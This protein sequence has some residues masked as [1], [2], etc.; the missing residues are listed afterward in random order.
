M[1]KGR[2]FTKRISLGLETKAGDLYV[3]NY[4]QNRAEDIKPMVM[5]KET[6]SGLELSEDRKSIGTW[7]TN[8]N[9]FASTKGFVN[10]ETETLDGNDALK[11]SATT[12][13][14]QSSNASVIKSIP[15]TA[16]ANAA[17]NTNYV[18]KFR[19]GGES[20]G[21]KESFSGAT[22]TTATTGERFIVR[23]DKKG[24]LRMLGTSLTNNNDAENVTTS[25]AF[26]SLTAN[27]LYD[28]EAV[29]NPST[30]VLKA[31]VTNADGEQVSRSTT[32]EGI[33]T[34]FAFRHQIKESDTTVAYFDDAEIGIIAPGGPVLDIATVASGDKDA[35]LLGETVEFTYDR[36]IDQS[37]LSEAVVT[38]KAGENEAKT[39]A[40][41]EYAIT[42]I[43]NKVKVTLL[44][45]INTGTEYTVA[46]TG[47]K[48]LAGGQTT[49]ADE[50]TYKT[51]AIDI[52]VA[53]FMFDEDSLKAKVNSYYA[54][55]K[56]VKLIAAVYNSAETQ[57]KD[58]KIAEFNADSKA[59]T[60]YVSIAL[61]ELAVE[62]GD[63][64]K[65]FLWSDFTT[66]IPYI[67]DISK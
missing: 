1:L 24:N 38:L 34:A 35:A 31:V 21:E 49:A 50:F 17:D 47:V 15:T 23:R 42:S 57:L 28:V 19:F 3:D 7:S 11:I 44:T 5:D 60:D 33:P 36:T 64:I 46:I 22:I 16:T 61:N 27:K 13:A 32:M 59:E 65:G 53:E 41:E 48:D 37:A 30:G 4:Y 56:K 6:F 51:S 10:V 63:K 20:G 39:L 52:Q 40:A 67:A 58:V 62:N 54:Q 26:E 43:G 14:E 66:M 12:T 29:Y 45:A 18:F 25:G 8:S 9:V 55:G 2:T